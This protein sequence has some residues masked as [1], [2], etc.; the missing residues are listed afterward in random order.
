MCS[1]SFLKY[2]KIAHN[3]FKNHFIRL[4]LYGFNLVRSFS[5]H[6]NN[7]DCLHNSK[8]KI[9][10]IYR[11]ETVK[12]SE[13]KR[14]KLPYA[15]THIVGLGEVS[16]NCIVLESFEHGIIKGVKVRMYEMQV[17][18]NSMPFGENKENLKS[19][20]ENTDTFFN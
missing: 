16:G 14:L 6:T 18:A 19:A 3:V 9:L 7:G 13:L 12:L 8:F 20:R 1:R 10:Y 5:G 17:P 2:F 15:E 11:K 4:P